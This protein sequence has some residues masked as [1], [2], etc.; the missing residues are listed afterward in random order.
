[1]VRFWPKA[2]GRHFRKADTCTAALGKSSRSATQVISMLGFVMA[3]AV[4]TIIR[5]IA[6]P[7]G[8]VVA[9]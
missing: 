4:V 2:D 5:R 1:M 8:V 6:I 7:A 3:Y 9:C